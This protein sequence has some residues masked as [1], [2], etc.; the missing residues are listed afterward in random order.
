[1]QRERTLP[2]DD[3]VV[4]TVRFLHGVIDKKFDLVHPL[5]H[6]EAAQ[7]IVP[8]EQGE[9]PRQYSPRR[10]TRRDTRLAD[11]ARQVELH[12]V[13]THYMALHKRQWGGRR[14]R[15]EAHR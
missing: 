3:S 10:P 1:M 14:Y 4:V 12:W 13:T 2:V 15:V 7:E 6:L 5:H 8:S 11:G 9:L